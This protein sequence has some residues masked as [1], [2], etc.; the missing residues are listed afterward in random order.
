MHRGVL[1]AAAAGLPTVVSPAVDAGLPDP[2]RGRCRV[3][4]TPDG[5]AA[6]IAAHL[7][8]PSDPETWQAAVRPLTWGRVMHRLGALLEDAASSPRRVSADGR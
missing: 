3:A 6:A 8:A 1:E 5:F 2:L 7:A 4:D